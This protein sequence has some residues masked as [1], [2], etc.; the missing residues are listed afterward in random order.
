MEVVRLEERDCRLLAARWAEHGN[1]VRR[2]AVALREADAQDVACRLKALRRLEK[3]F[4]VDLGSLCHKWLHRDH[5]RTHPLE[6]EVMGWVAQAQVRADGT[7]ELT[8]IVDRVRQ[9]RSLMAG[10]LGVG[11]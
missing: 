7:L 3:S 5:P 2:M 4:A 1:S 8:V 6:R 9:L 11:G 10:Q